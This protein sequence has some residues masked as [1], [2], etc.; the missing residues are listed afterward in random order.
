MNYVIESDNLIAL[1]R[2]LPEYEGKIDVM[3]VDPPYNTDIAGIGYKDSGYNEGWISFMK[4]RLEV[5][6][7][8]L[9][10]HGVMF[11][12][13]DENEFI[14]L[15]GL[16]SDIFGGENLISMI[17]KKTNPRFDKNRKE[18]PLESGLRRTHEFVIAC[19]KN[20]KNTILNPILQPVWN[21]TEYVET[22]KPMETVLDD[23][24]T[25]AS[26]KDE[27]AELMG[28][29]G[30]FSTPKPVKLIKEFI[31]SASTKTSTVLDFFAGSG[32]TGHAVMQLNA[33]DNGDRKF[34]LI[35][36][37]ESDI[38]R[39]VTIPRILKV[40]QSLNASNIKILQF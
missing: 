29:S 31:R 32:T 34:I 10:S 17:W 6:Y 13:I 11:I 19:F 3:P 33:E 4:E 20:R 9:S 23:L 30:S 40:A 35:T 25:T 5:A 26:A 24:G 8:L 18:K 15:W 1:K 21:G 16:C 2:L 28:E 22:L 7:Q 37:N 27:L 36:N 39:R 14:S 12:H 38:C